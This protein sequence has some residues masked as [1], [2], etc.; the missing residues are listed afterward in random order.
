MGRQ[1]ILQQQSV[2]V[3]PGLNLVLFCAI[4]ILEQEVLTEAGLVLGDGNTV[5]S[6]QTT[7]RRYSI[8]TFV[9]DKNGTEIKQGQN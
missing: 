5:R 2:Q 8:C 4:L 3:L 7:T 1:H 9:R 6:E